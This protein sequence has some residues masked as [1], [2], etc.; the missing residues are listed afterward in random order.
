MCSEKHV[1][2]KT[3]ISNLNDF[4]SKKL[5]G[6]LISNE[7]CYSDYS[8]LNEDKSDYGLNWS[9]IANETNWNW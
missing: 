8:I 4:Y 2:L 5:K 6:L 3:D 1:S 7:T 9:L